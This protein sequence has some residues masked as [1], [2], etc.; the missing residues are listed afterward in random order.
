MEIQIKGDFEIAVGNEDL[1]YE[2]TAWEV[3]SKGFGLLY[4][5]E[6][7]SFDEA[8]RCILEKIAEIIDSEWQKPQEADHYSLHFE[9]RALQT[10][11]EKEKK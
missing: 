4:S 2:I 9:N 10:L 3:Y 7:T 6:A 1:K 8:K 5:G 11:K